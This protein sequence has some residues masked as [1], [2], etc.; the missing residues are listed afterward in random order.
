[1]RT[2]TCRTWKALS[3]RISDLETDRMEMEYSFSAHEIA[4][5]AMEVEEKGC[6]FYRHLSDEAEDD[7]VRNMCVFL[8]EQEEEHKKTF[9]TIAS[10]FR[11]Q[12]AE[13]SYSVDVRA[14][15]RTS[16]DEILALFSSH[17]DRLLDE[18]GIAGCLDL[19]RRIEETSVQ[20]YGHMHG[21]YS[22]RFSAVLERIVLEEQ[23]HLRMVNDVLSKTYP[24]TFVAAS[25]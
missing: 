8:S 7:T 11:G 23:E 14:L 5:L 2:L 17:R 20:V 24:Q 6:A 16:L 1:M 21:V 3:D 25:Q 18:G 4:E 12:A 19:A 9:R 15:L 22:E 13:F 10:H